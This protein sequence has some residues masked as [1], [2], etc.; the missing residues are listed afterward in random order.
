MSCTEQI[1]DII[2]VWPFADGKINFKHPFNIPKEV[3]TVADLG[4]AKIEKLLY[5]RHFSSCGD[6]Y[7]M[8]V[9]GFSENSAELSVSTS[10]RDS[11][12]SYTLKLTIPI[13]MDERLTDSDILLFRRRCDFLIQFANERFALI[14]STSGGYSFTKSVSIANKKKVS[15]LV[16][17]VKNLNGLQDIQLT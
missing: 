8:G 2:S 9:I 13:Y 6:R 5:N 10:D 17:T 12:F 14:R 1:K 16:F 11:V 4:V 15:Q 7:G 3:Y